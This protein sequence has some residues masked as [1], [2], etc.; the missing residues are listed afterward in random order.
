MEEM[1]PDNSVV[2][3]GWK[4]PN[5]V[6]SRIFFSGQLAHAY[7]LVGPQGMRKQELAMH[8]AKLLLCSSPKLD[9]SLCEPCGLCLSC[10][11][12]E[13]GTHPDLVIIRP[14]SSMIRIEQVRELQK[15]LAF[16]PLEADRRVCLI[17][18]MEKI[19]LQAANSLLKTLEEPPS[20]THLI[21]TATSTKSLLPTIVSRCQ[22]IHL[23][24]E[25][26]EGIKDEID[27]EKLGGEGEAHFL[28]LIAE[29][30]LS[31]VREFLER[32]GLGLRTEFFTFLS[33]CKGMS[34]L[35]NLFKF[36]DRISK[37]EEDLLLALQVIRSVIRDLMALRVIQ[38]IGTEPAGFDEI[39]F[40]QDRREELKDLVYFFDN[41]DL[42]EY[43]QWLSMAE[44]FLRRNINREI[45]AETAL[46]FWYRRKMFRW[47]RKS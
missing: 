34:G 2:S 35:T 11:K 24:G 32:D 13:R 27:R 14:E 44:S 37:S 41:Y 5:K 30:S 31:R 7:L 25:G 46:I 12:T 39:L 28:A 22:L 21:L 38:S 20:K 3:G 45:L 33:S 1:E 40:N 19:N 42:V 23:G 18:G 36:V 47:D 29:G 15:N 10:R 4:V 8:W 17:L 43:S 6:F 16:S 26:I 9:Q